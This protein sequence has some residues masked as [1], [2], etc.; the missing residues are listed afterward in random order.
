[1]SHHQN[2][3]HRVSKVIV[4]LWII[5]AIIQEGNKGTPITRE[6]SSSKKEGLADKEMNP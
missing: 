2:G 5:I 6:A 4:H 1:M 3:D